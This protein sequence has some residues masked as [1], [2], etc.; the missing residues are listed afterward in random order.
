[1]AEALN[2]L[3]LRM[4]HELTR[5]RRRA[6]AYDADP[7]QVLTEAFREMTALVEDLDDAAR[8]AVSLR[9]ELE[10]VQRRHR[11]SFL[12]FFEAVPGACLITD[13][14]GIVE[15]ANQAARELLGTDVP[16]AVREPM[17]AFVAEGDRRWVWAAVR[18]A[19]DPAEQG[20]W[21]LTMVPRRGEPF[22]ASVAVASGEGDRLYWTVRDVTR[23]ERRA[24]ELDRTRTLRTRVSDARQ[25]F[26]LAMAHDLR[27]PVSGILAGVQAIESYGD[28]LPEDARAALASIQ[29]NGDELRRLRTQFFDLERLGRRAVN[30]R[31]GRTD[32]SELVER[33][34][35]TVDLGDRS[36]QLDLAEVEADVDPGLLESIVRN[37][38]ENAARHTPPLTR[39]WVRVAAES[40]QVLLVTVEDDGPGVPADQRE[41]IFEMFGRIDPDD[42]SGGMG[43]GLYLARRFAEI[44]GGRAWV[45]EREGGGASFRIALPLG[46]AE[47]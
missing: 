25:A 30:P 47:R 12:D 31:R 32:V 43:A 20:A 9:H 42:R 41:A 17:A 45:E 34:A 4:R 22:P 38:L 37:L 6:N 19:R 7:R 8:A 5:L 18:S 3:V 15:E 28:E 14:S 16:E 26:F 10:V 46:D 23:E 36:L 1:M 13:G 33:S 21:R 2:E 44:Q 40:D 39:V 11:Q 27:A 29:A 24:G 35:K